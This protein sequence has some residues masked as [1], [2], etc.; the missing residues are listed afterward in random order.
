VSRQAE[1]TALGGRQSL[2]NVTRLLGNRY[3]H[4]L[5]SEVDV[6]SHSLSVASIE[7]HSRNDLGS[8]RRERL[9]REAL[10]SCSAP[11]NDSC[12]AD[13]EALDDRLETVLADWGAIG[14]R[15]GE[16]SQP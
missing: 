12:V 3:A 9:R 16:R 6:S 13:A 15:A 4:V 14:G 11:P 1:W 2:S 8:A 5:A 10:V 7:D